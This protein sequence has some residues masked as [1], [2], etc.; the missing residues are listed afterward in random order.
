[1]TTLEVR[2]TR[3]VYGVVSAYLSHARLT[4]ADEVPG[5]E[6]MLVSIR[7]SSELRGRDDPREGVDEEN[8]GSE[9]C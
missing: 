9:S 8:G 2:R 1:M 5:T 6:D 7:H 4:G 3:S